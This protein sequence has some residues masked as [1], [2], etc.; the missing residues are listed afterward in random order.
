MLAELVP[1]PPAGVPAL[2]LLALLSESSDSVSIGSG[3]SSL[4]AWITIPSSSSSWSDILASRTGAVVLGAEE[5]AAGVVETDVVVWV[6]V[7]LVVKTPAAAVVV[8]VLVVVALALVVKTQVEGCGASAAAG[9]SAI[10]VG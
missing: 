4:E 7:A 8:P 1:E 6:L 10:G 3:L 5:E 2:T 9:L